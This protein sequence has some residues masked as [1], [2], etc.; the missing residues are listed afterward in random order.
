MLTEERQQLIARYVDEHQICRVAELCQLTSSSESTIR[1]DLSEMEDQGRLKRVHG[2]ARSIQTFGQDVAQKIRFTMNHADKEAI[3]KKAASKVR[4]HDYL[5]L[6]AGTTIYEMVP[7]LAKIPDLHVVTNGMDT[8][9]ALTDAGISTCM[10]GGRVKEET[11]ATVGVTTVAKLKQ[12]N[13]N[14]AFIGA[15]A[16]SQQGSLTTPDTEEAEVKKTAIAQS[17][18]AFVL[19]D[20]SKINEVTFAEFAKSEEIT[21]ISKLKKDDRQYL[22][23]NIQLEE[24]E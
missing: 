20:R 24:A 5:F 13:F 15:N 2:G 14:S 23:V 1:R 8:A 4:P 7:F 6:D 16:L 22:P 19:L 10:L 9:L 12:L 3:A 11:H 17:Q 21:L 18:H